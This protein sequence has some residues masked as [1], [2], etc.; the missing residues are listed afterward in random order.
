MRINN[1]PYGKY[2]HL[3]FKKKKKKRFSFHFPHLG[4]KDVANVVNLVCSL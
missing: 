1:I 3:L 2:I 4:K